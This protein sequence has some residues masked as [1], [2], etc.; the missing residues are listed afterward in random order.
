MVM[1]LIRAVNLFCQLLI[2]LILARAI[3]SWFFRPGDKMYS[4]YTMILR[5]TDPILQPSR[6][7]LGRLGSGSGVD[8]SPVL[9]LILIQILNWL[10]V[11]LLKMFLL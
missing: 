7:L 1:L 3:M 11:S 9:A 6:R 10:V 8:F 5:V 4:F 2:Y